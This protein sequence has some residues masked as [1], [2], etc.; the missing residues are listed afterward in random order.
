MV[1]AIAWGKNR[2]YMHVPCVVARSVS[3]DVRDANE[4]TTAG[5]STK[6]PT[7]DS[8]G[9]NA[10]TAASLLHKAK[11]HDLWQLQLLLMLQPGSITHTHRILVRGQSRPARIPGKHRVVPGGLV[12]APD[13]EI[14]GRASVA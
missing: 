4:Y 2:E 13:Y 6:D 7:F 5:L 1:S 11:F 8:T 3:Y 12:K 14:C 9:R 10:K